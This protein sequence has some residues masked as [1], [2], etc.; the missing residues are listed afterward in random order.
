MHDKTD[1]QG[2]CLSGLRLGIDVH[3]NVESNTKNLEG[4]CQRVLCVSSLIGQ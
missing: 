3:V 1:E 4:D 2:K